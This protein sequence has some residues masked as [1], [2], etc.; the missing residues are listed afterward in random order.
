M[1]RRRPPRFVFPQRKYDQVASERHWELLH[2][3]FDRNLKSSLMTVLP[4]SCT[5]IAVPDPPLRYQLPTLF[6]T[7]SATGYGYA[8]GHR[9]RN[10]HLWV[11]DPSNSRVSRRVMVISWLVRL[12]ITAT[13]LRGDE[14]VTEV[15]PSP[16]NSDVGL[17]TQKSPLMEES[18][19]KEPS[20]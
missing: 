5:Q 18:L 16:Q 11:D 6:T 8:E 17:I 1:D 9:C 14:L 7:K 20:G 19:F 15:V 4:A 2:S 10:S 13:G 3:L 12:S